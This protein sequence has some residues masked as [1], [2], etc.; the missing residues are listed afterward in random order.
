MWFCG[1]TPRTDFRSPSRFYDLNVPHDDTRALRSSLEYGNIQ[2]DT[3]NSG[4]KLVRCD[5]DPHV[6]RKHCLDHV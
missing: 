4:L 3:G 1:G 6:A 2:L 5:C